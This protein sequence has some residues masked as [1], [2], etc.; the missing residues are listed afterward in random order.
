MVAERLIF[1]YRFIYFQISNKIILI[2]F[3]FSIK[4]ELKFS[5]FFIS[6]K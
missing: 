4:G 2:K 5:L 6:K 3:N 1:F